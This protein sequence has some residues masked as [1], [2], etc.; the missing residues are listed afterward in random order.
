MD[1]TNPCWDTIW[2]SLH[3]KKVAPKFGKTAFWNQ[4]APEFTQAVRKS[5]YIL[6]L[7]EIMNPQPDWTV[8]DMG[9]AAG[10]VAIPLA[11]KVQSVTAV[12]PSPRMRELLQQQ[13]E[14]KGI[15][16]IRIVDGSW[17]QD[18]KTLGIQTHDIVLGSRSLVIHDLKAAIEKA[19][20]FARQGVFLSTLVGNGPHDPRIINAV[21]REFK[22]GT[23]YVVVVNLLRQM[24]I[25][26]NVSFTYN[27]E[28]KMYPDYEAAFNDM[29]WMVHDLSAKEES[30]LREY[31]KKTL[32]PSDEGLTMPDSRP[33]R[34]AVLSWD[35][36]YGRDIESAEGRM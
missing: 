20:R 32:V 35:K 18:W 6:Q 19:H 21:G 28:H 13:C 26:A 29:L 12:D 24:G 15:D 5:D 1:M 4:R 7:I 3:E 14:A 31:L 36:K 30:A 25:Y 34:W 17:E 33:V 11:Q 16:N 23:D 22:P 27:D 2:K 9:C 8:L 10:T